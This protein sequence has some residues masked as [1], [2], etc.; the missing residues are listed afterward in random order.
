MKEIRRETKIAVLDIGGT[1]IKSG[2]FMNGK[3]IEKREEPTEAKYG[4]NYVVEKA[5]TI[6]DVLKD[7]YGEVERIGIS[8]AGQ[9][10]SSKGLIKY[11]NSNIPDYTGMKIKDKIEKIFHV[12][13]SVEND[14]NSAAIGEAY[15]GAGKDEPDFLCLTY[16]TGV[17]GAI[18]VKKQIYHGSNFSAGEFGGILIHPEERNAEDNFSGCYER[19]A[20]ATALVE[21]VLKIDATCTNGREIFE[22]IH[23]TKI[24]NEVNQWCREIAYG[25]VSLT[26]IFNPSA[27]ILGGGVMEQ[28]YV[29]EKVKET[30]Y[31]NIIESFKNVKIKQ[32]ELGNQAGLLG[33]AVLALQEK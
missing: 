33:A 17:G 16:G 15:Y 30:L 26:H 3:L 29:L 23:E 8:T 11:A 6:I 14:V 25:L 2:L 22:K 19:Y 28:N 9:V 10:D 31:N 7:K 4:G 27:I 20:S 18:I 1:S 21:N 5:I 12:P 13:V 24:Q 32:A